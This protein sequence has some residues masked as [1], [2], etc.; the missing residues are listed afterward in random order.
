[1]EIGLETVAQTAR[2]MGIRTE[3]ERFES[4]AI[5]AAEVIP[6]QMAEAYSAYATLG[7]KASPFAIE[8]VESADGEILWSLE[9]ENTR[10]LD[11]PVARIMVDILEDVVNRGT[12]T[13]IRTVAGLPYDVPVAGKTGT[14]NNSTDTWFLGFTPNL[15]AVVW[16]GM[17][18]P[19]ELRPNATGGGDA[20]PVW[21]EF[22]RTVYYGSGEESDP[23]FEPML[24]V[25]EP[26]EVVDGLTTRVVDKAT[27]RLASEWCPEEDRY[28]ELF[29]PGTE[30][31]ELCDRSG[32]DLL[33]RLRIPG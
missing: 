21:G 10:V 23:G 19:K 15:L 25:P 1:M 17:D 7:V 8:R 20:A 9:P 28:T 22:A 16:F 31:T 11:P 27:G 29:L 24:P 12:A 4:T 5:G 33:R 6:I 13:S 32:A 14:T 30:P 2:R 18:L 26:W 3:V